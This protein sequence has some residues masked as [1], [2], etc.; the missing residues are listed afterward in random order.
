MEINQETIRQATQFLVAGGEVKAANVLRACTLDKWEIVDSWM[1]G[2]RQLD[3][4]LIEV[5]CPRASYDI[6]I[7]S[8]NPITQSIE[9]SLRAVLPSDVYLKNL[10]A[11]AAPQKKPTIE[12]KLSTTEIEILVKALEMQKALMI[13]VSTGGPLVKE[14]KGEYEQRR[15]VIEGLLSK[16]DIDDPN[17]YPD[18]W[19]WHGKWSDGSLPS[20]Q[21]RRRYIADIYQPLL[22]ALT[23]SAKSTHVQPLEPTGWARV[24]RNVDKIVHALEWARNEEDFQ[25][26]GLLCR[27]AIISL[28]QAVYN[29][30][31]HEPPD[32]IT[33]SAT[34][35]KRM[36]EGY[37]SSELAGSAHDSQRKYAKA[38]FDLAVT[39]QHRRTAT[40]RDAALCA[41]ATRAIINMIAII[42]GQRDPEI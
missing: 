17:P 37:I 42:S 2:N 22:D 19:T 15:M 41:E 33:P 26:V 7:D 40:F 11:R 24:D 13:S 20:Y 21:S 8:S 35:A 28:A 31:I 18:L 39:V 5:S 38:S 14:V 4:L 3:G 1:D 25:A 16:A 9:K 23:S 29:P 10:C 12:P 32:G 6:L 34:D 36:I 27:E 30:D